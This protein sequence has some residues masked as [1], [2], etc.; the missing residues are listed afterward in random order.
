[1]VHKTKAVILRTVK[2][3]ETS[4]ICTA[5]TSIFGLQ[6][7]LVKGIRK[8]TKRSSGSINYF[9]PGSILQMEVY[10]NPLKQLQYIKE[11]QW[12]HL[13][14]SVFF[15]VV[16][17]SMIQFMVELI[18]KTV[19]EPEA[20]SELF[21]LIES[22]FIAIDQQDQKDAVNIP[23]YFI[24]HLAKILGFQINGK[25]DADHTILDFEEGSFSSEIPAHDRYL[26][27][28]D[29]A[30]SYKLLNHKN[31]HE[32]VEISLNRIRRRDLLKSYQLFLAIHI[33]DFSELKSFSL[34]QQI[35]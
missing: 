31:I 3:G 18:L 9:Q 24:L 11:Y 7:Y 4:I 34:L 27:N 21:D 33:E 16:K 5:F 14:N 29:A 19:K 20:N 35:F 1:M 8:T 12:S 32:P 2:Y 10:H 30:I 13:Y 25:Y 26:A 22:S 15:D 23:L 17:N 28:E 6:S